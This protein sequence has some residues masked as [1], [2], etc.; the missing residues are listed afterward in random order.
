M[1]NPPVFKDQQEHLKIADDVRREIFRNMS[2]QR[3]LELAFGLRDTAKK[4]KAMGLR[5]AHP[6]WT[7]QQVQDKVR[8]IFLYARS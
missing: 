2:P 4:L 3:K 6:D 8:E 5:Q 1:E 7:E